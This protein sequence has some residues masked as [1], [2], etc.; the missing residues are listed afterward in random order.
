MK[1]DDLLSKIPLERF[2]NPPPVVSVL[3][4]AGV[5]GRMGPMRGGLNI[6]GLAAR[7][8]AAFKP[9]H[10]KAVALAINSPGGSPVQSALIAKRIR[11]L[12]DEK[13]VP[14]LAFCED[15]AASGGYWLAT[16]ADEIYAD[17]SSIVGSIGVINSGFGFDKWIEAHGISRRVYTAGEHKS[18][19]DPFKAED[20]KDVERLQALLKELHENFKAQVKERRGDKLTGDEETLFSGEFWTGRE[21]VELGLIDGLGDLRTVL[22]DRYGEKVRPRFVGDRQGWLRRKLGLGPI[23]DPH[24]WTDAFVSAAEERALWQRYGL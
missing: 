21:A 20:P 16:A 3:P 2:Q 13:D 14:V 1:L 5:I 24:V 9:R 15:V 19:L 4:L 17:P 11:S 18:K 23:A 12:A 6:A 10:L 22:R 7:I 8:E